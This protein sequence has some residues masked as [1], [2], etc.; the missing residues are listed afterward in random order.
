VDASGNVLVV[1]GFNGAASI[2]GAMLTSAGMR[3]AFV[4]KLDP[5][6]TPLF[7]RSFGGSGDDYAF[8]VAADPL[9]ELFVTGVFSSTIDLGGGELTSEGLSDA[10]AVKLDAAGQHLWSARFGGPGADEGQDLSVHEAT[11]DVVLTGTFS[12]TIDFGGQGVDVLTSAGNRDIFVARLT[13]AGEHLFSRG[14]GDAEDQLSTDFDTGARVNVAV[15][16]AGNILLSGP[17]F[18]SADFGGGSLMSRGRT[19]VYLVKLDPAG[20]HVYGARFGDGATQVGLDVVVDAAGQAVIAGRS[21]G[22]IDFGQ[23]VL[24]NAGQGD[25]FLAKLTLGPSQ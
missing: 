19:D 10:F 5:G 6:G 15:D 22:S 18:G 4:L 20:A 13:G 7:V 9:G 8:G 12:S 2:G 3:D 11:G 14:F 23:G 21:Y 16:T 17:M 24:R 25:A 1:G